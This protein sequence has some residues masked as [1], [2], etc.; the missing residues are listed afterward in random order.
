MSRNTITLF[1][2]HRPK[3]LDLAET[4]NSY[5]TRRPQPYVKELLFLFHLYLYL[6]L[7]TV[8]SNIQD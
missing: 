8:Y 1:I 4:S 5:Y 7:V 2:Y 3:L 6:L